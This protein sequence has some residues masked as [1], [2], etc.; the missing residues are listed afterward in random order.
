MQLNHSLLIIENC[1]L[2][3]F[4]MTLY[5]D[6]LA[7]DESSGEVS[8][9]GASYGVP[10]AGPARSVPPDSVFMREIVETR[11]VPGSRWI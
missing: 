11:S 10:E 7:G 2:H 5:S 9:T 6:M 4:R 3:F 8:A 1:G